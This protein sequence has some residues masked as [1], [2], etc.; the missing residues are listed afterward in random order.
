MKQCEKFTIPQNRRHWLQT[1]G[2]GFG[3][4]AFHALS[5]QIAA[6]AEPSLSTQALHHTPKAKRVIFL[7]MKGGP[8]HVDTFDPKPLLDRDHGKPLP[9]DLPRVTFA[10]QGNLLRSPWQFKRY[11]QSG[12]PV[13]ELFPNVARHVD[14]LCMLR[15]VHGTNPA[16]GGALLKLHT[17]SDQFVRPSLGSWLT[18]GLGTE[19]ENLPAFVT[20]CPTLAHG[21]VNNWGAAFLP[22]PP[23]GT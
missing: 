10:K 11:G 1:T 9:F 18:Y 22:P 3:A 8:S 16:H 15:S 20:I 5:Q 17:G 21:G 7:F 19:N 6:A 14:D 12:L 2:C 23:P 4:V 13:S